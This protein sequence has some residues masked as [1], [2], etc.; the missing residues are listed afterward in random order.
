[1]AGVATDPTREPGPDALVVAH[2]RILA[3]RRHDLSTYSAGDEAVV[4]FG[5]G[6]LQFLDMRTPAGTKLGEGGAFEWSVPVGAAGTAA[7]AALE[8]PG[9]DGVNTWT[10]VCNSVRWQ[11]ACRG[12]ETLIAHCR[13]AALSRSASL[14]YRVV[15]RERGD[16]VVEGEFTFVAIHADEQGAYVIDPRRRPG[17][18]ASA[19]LPQ[20]P[21]RS[22]T[23]APSLDPMPLE[24]RSSGAADVGAR[25]DSLWTPGAPPLRWMGE[26]PMAPLFRLEPPQLLRSKGSAGDQGAV[27]E[28]RYPRDLLRLLGYPLAGA[29]EPLGRRHHPYG[30]LLEGMG[31]H[32]A[33]AISAATAPESL[34]V[35]W[36]APTRGEEDFRLRS[37]LDARDGDRITSSHVIYEGERAVGSVRV[38]V[39][40]AS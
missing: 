24:R 8:P 6:L 11:R 2:P 33:L 34:F 20:R 16:L 35:E 38:D 12:D 23:K 13:I 32:A 21:P 30:R 1:M 14:P 10:G 7:Y 18:P 4:E 28:W 36:W 25:I 15:S 27:W 17:D 40:E 26:P 31:V 9:Y 22:V 5:P 19:R 37:T 29:S 39:R 3:A